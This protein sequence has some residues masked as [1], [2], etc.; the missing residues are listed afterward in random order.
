MSA[1]PPT[2]P[3]PPPT[4][5]TPTVPTNVTIP[6][7]VVILPNDEEHHGVSL[8]I[9]V[10]RDRN[11]S[12]DAPDVDTGKRSILAFRVETEKGKQVRLRMTLKGN[13]EH[14]FLPGQLYEGPPRS[15]HDVLAPGMLKAN[16][17]NTLTLRVMDGESRITVSDI[18][19]FYQAKKT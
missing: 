16:G 4:G 8:K 10:D 18:V 2:T 14:V 9:G 17:R 11:F 13:G 1:T 12:F 15:W 3:T 5:T 19:L 6:A 7:Y